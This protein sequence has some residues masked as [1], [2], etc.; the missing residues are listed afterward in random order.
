MATEVLFEKKLSELNSFVKVVH[1]LRYI[2][3]QETFVRIGSYLKQ[4]YELLQSSD[5]LNFIEEDFRKVIDK[6]DNR[7]NFKIFLSNFRIIEGYYFEYLKIY[8]LTLRIGGTVLGRVVLSEE[9]IKTLCDYKSEILNSFN[10][11]SNK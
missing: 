9:E 2:N 5:R 11:G 3:S 4:T 7:S 8:Q 1:V 6:I 10:D